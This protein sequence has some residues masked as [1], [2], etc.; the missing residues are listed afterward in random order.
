MRRGTRRVDALRYF[1]AGKIALVAVPRIVRM[2]W[3]LDHDG[4]AAA[5]AEAERMA[6]RRR[7]LRLGPAGIAAVVH[8][9]ASFLPPRLN[10][11]PQA[12]TLWSLTRAAGMP[13]ELKI[14]VAPRNDD[15][16]RIEAHAWVE[17]YGCAL[18]ESAERYV[19]LPIDGQRS[20]GVSGWAGSKSLRHPD[21]HKISQFTR[22]GFTPCRAWRKHPR[23]G[24]NDT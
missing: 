16:Q 9:V 22:L 14:G 24:V 2:R 11:L 18:G 10:C 4:Y 21:P 19:S 12:L 23:K 3:V 6:R 1:D 17:L 7:S 15:G 20:V 8:R 5:R 13:T